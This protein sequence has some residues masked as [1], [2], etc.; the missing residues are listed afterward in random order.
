MDSFVLSLFNKFFYKYS[1][2]KLF[3]ISHI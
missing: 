3:L 2:Q 1:S